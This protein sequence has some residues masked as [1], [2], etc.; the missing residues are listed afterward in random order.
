M[1][2]GLAKVRGGRWWVRWWVGAEEVWRGDVPVCVQVMVTSKGER[3]C[4]PCRVPISAIVFQLCVLMHFPFTTN[5]PSLPTPPPLSF[6]AFLPSFVL[7]LLQLALNEYADET[8][9]E[10]AAKRLGLKISQEQLK[11]R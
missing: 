8:W 11:A 5:D 9:E 4:M 2:W 6:L 7:F 1:G 10:F 3:A